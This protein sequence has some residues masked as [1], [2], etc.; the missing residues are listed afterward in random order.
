MMSVRD[1]DQCQI[2]GVDGGKQKIKPLLDPVSGQ[3][4]KD[5]KALLGI[6][7]GFQKLS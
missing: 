4:D 3:S 1:W 2:K 6:I 7:V 5:E